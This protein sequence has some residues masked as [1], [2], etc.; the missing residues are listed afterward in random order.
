MICRPCVPDNITT[1]RGGFS[2]QLWDSDCPTSV[3]ITD[4]QP[5]APV[6]GGLNVAVQQLHTAVPLS[7]LQLRAAQQGCILTIGSIC[8][9]QLHSP[10]NSDVILLRELQLASNDAIEATQRTQVWITGACGLRKG[11]LGKE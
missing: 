8:K 6:A 5:L 4:S 7:Q 11:R 2:I 3:S 10:L 1:D 9:K